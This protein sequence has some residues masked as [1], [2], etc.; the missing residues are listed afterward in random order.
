MFKREFIR[1]KKRIDERN[2][3]TVSIEPVDDDSPGLDLPSNAPSAEDMFA[4]EEQRRKFEEVLNRLKPSDAHILVEV[5]I[6]GLTHEEMGQKLGIEG[7]AAKTRLSR[8]KRAFREEW[9]RAYGVYGTERTL[10]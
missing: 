5:G 7:N 3:R 2:Q 6:H 4:L 1:L 8:A 10:P 9:H